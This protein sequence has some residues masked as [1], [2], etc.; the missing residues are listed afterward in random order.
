M[1][2][3]AVVFISMFMHAGSA[4]TMA[5]SGIRRIG[6]R[7]KILRRATRQLAMAAD[8]FDYLVIGGGSGGIASARRAAQWGAKVAVVERGALGGTCVNVGCVPKKVMFNAALVNEMMHA[9]KHYGFTG[10]TEGAKFDWGA[11]KASRDK[12]ITRLNGIYGNNLGNNGVE[13]IT[14]LAS[15]VGTN[16]VAVGDKTFTADHVCIAVGGKTKMPNIPG[17]EHCIDSDG[18]FDLEALP[19][20]VL[21]VGAGYIAVELAGIFNALESDTTL[22]VRGDKALRL[23]DPILSDTLAGEMQK[24]GLRVLNHS[25]PKSVTKESD[26][27]LTMETEDGTRHE[28]FETI[29]MAI[30]REPL[31]APLAL[32]KAGVALQE[33]SKYIAVDAF[34]TTS[35]EGGT[36]Y[37]LGDV[38]GNVELTP[39]AIAAGRRLSDRLFGGKK[40]SKADYDMVPTVVFSHPTIGTIGLT[41]GEAIAKFGE[42]QIKTYTSTFVNLFYGPW[43]M[44]PSDKP[45]TAMK[46]VCQ[47]EE[48]KVV[49]LHTIGMGSDELLQGFGVAMKMGCTKEDLDA[50]I[51]LHPT[52][53]E[54]LVTMAPW[55]LY[56][57]PAPKERV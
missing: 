29:L 37:A 16:E 27:T 43:Q 11:I 31:I 51:A 18:F 52:A 30:G 39:T 55:G 42:D 10:V 41:E 14:G 23:F 53:A 22:M 44:E 35:A 15:F 21:V 32:D 54:E 9:A 8:H 40:Q 57:S 4:L 19:K 6:A 34:Q 24:Q 7:P 20:K 5:Q 33:G 46:L 1:Q 38:C 49:G 36:V 3:L 28:G 48:E 50:C 25:T 17:I 13:I 12:Y 2:K 45:K 47:G 56:K 26:G